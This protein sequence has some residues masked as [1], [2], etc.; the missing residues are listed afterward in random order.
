MKKLKLFFF[1]GKN[2]KRKIVR[3]NLFKFLHGLKNYSAFFCCDKTEI[4]F[5]MENGWVFFSGEVCERVQFNEKLNRNFHH[6]LSQ[7]YPNS[8]R[9]S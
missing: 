8:T 2:M 1:G 5:H 6:Q 7:N 4:W 9:K 3:E